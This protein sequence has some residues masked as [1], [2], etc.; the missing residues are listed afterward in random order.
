[1]RASGAKA[2]DRFNFYRGAE[3]PLFHGAANVGHAYIWIAGAK[4]H[5]SPVLLVVRLKPYPDTNLLRHD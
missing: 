2:P 3:A 1:L 5:V 4:A